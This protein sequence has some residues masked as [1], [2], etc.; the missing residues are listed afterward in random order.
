MPVDNISEGH[1]HDRN[2]LNTVCLFS[3]GQHTIFL[4]LLNLHTKYNP[5]LE[6]SYLPYFFIFQC[7]K[8]A[9]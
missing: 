4:P 8:P 3:E 9:I 1:F 2:N 6:Y 5:H 7:I